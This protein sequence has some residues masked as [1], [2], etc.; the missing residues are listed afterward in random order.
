[1]PEALLPPDRLSRVLTLLYYLLDE[2]K[3]STIELTRI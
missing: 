2:E 1:M 3:G